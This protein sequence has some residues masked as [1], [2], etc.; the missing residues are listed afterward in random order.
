MLCARSG[1]S[2]PRYVVSSFVFRQYRYTDFDQTVEMKLN[3]SYFNV[4]NVGI[5]NIC[6]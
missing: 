5:S 4:N 3:R 1:I 6:L 2:K